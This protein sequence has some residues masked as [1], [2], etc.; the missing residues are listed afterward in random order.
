M[1]TADV[2]PPATS[3]EPKFEWD[4]DVPDTPFWKD[5]EFTVARNFLTCYQP[6]DIERM[7]LDGSLCVH[8]RLLYLLSELQS[9]LSAREVAVAPQQLHVA[10]SRTW[11]NLL[12]GIATIQQFLDRPKDE[13]ETI[14]KL[15]A[16]TEGR[17]QYSWL[18]MMS[19]LSLRSGNFASAEAAAREVLPVMQTHEK[20]GPDSPQA[21]G[22][23]RTI[24]A[25][26]WKQGGAKED[27]ARRLAEETSA[28]IEG[29]GCSKFAKYQEEERE[30]LRELTE[31][32]EKGEDAVHV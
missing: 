10:D 20:C 12:L 14:S 24:I 13:E 30:M 19:G 21:L 23:T 11:I 28:L 17:I 8:D 32:L 3:Q 7:K 16:T 9:T 1:S 15:I 25:S 5:M 22:T 6:Q 26:M 31:K 29:M 2:K 18:N 4:F 27:E